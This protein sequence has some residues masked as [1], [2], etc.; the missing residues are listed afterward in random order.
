M[1]NRRSLLTSALL[2]AA[3]RK[4]PLPAWVSPALAQDKPA[5]KAAAAQWRH[6]MSAF[7]ELKYAAGFK[8]FDYVNAQAPKGGAAWQIA[9][10]TYDSFNTVVAGIK[11]TPAAGIDQIY[12]T[13]FVSALDEP[14]SDY[15]L[16]AEAVAYPDDFSS[17][18][19]RLRPQAK[20]QDGKPVT[21]EDVI[22]S[23]QSFKKLSPQF[24]ATLRHVAKAE[25]TGDHEVT[26]TF[27]AAGDSKLPKAVGQL[28]VLPKHWWEGIDKNGKKRN[29]GE[30]TLEPPLGSG[31]YRIKEF[32]AGRNVI[33]ERVNDY[34]GKDLNVNIGRNNFENLRYEYFRDATVAIEVVQGRPRRLAR[35]E[36]RQELGD[37]LR[38][39]GGAREARHPRGISHQQYRPDAGLRVQHPARQIQRSARASCLEL[40]VQFRRDEQADILRPVPSHHQLFP[41]HRSR[42]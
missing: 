7:G 12:D 42:L 41:G 25:K 31:P 1:I 29:I 20:W 27:S 30:T 14:A 37:G 28:T 39:P 40:R 19:F 8:Q 3:A 24:A 26:F 16:I 11:G 5:A 9:L 32:S 2:L 6:G 34:W 22:F 33:Y 38:L 23:F 18:T 35:G 4:L 13:L 15:G 10:G 36:Q 17:A 21:P